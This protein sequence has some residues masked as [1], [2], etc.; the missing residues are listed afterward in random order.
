MSNNKWIWNNVDGYDGNAGEQGE[1]SKQIL[2]KGIVVGGR[3]ESE[4]RQLVGEI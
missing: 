1:L 3:N 2:L 4:S